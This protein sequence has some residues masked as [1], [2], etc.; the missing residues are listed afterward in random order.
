MLFILHIVRSF[1]MKWRHKNG[2]G[3]VS[4]HPFIINN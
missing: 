1:A 4:I 2:V 3:D